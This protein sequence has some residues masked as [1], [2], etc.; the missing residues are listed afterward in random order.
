[1]G[2]LI[3]WLCLERWGT[4][5]WS[6]WCAPTATWLRWSWGRWTTSWLSPATDSGT[7]SHIRRRCRGIYSW[8]SLSVYL[9]IYLSIYWSNYLSICLYFECD[10]LWDGVTYTESVQG[11]IFMD[12]FSYLSVYL[13]VYLSMCLSVCQLVCLS[14]CL[15]VCL[16]V[17]FWLRGLWYG[18]HFHM[19][20]QGNIFK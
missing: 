12:L 16:Y 18:G 15:F 19:A 5:V 11:Y 20:V 13:S 7:G 14:V 9:L 10:G 4:P 8:S 1:M 2:R 6:R 3:D 17:Y